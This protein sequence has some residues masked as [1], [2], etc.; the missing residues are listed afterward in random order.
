MGYALITTDYVATAMETTFSTAEKNKCSQL[1]DEVSE[2]VFAQTDEDFLDPNL[3]TEVPASIRG[4][5]C[6]AVIRGM[7]SEPTNLKSQQVGDVVEEFGGLLDYPPGDQR[8]LD[9]YGAGTGTFH[10]DGGCYQ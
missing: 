2:D 1:I 4:V 6:R 9:Q 7:L 5:V 3:Y 8:Q 10:L